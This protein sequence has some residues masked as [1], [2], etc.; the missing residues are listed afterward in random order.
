MDRRQIIAELDALTTAVKA[1]MPA[2]A[3]CEIEWM[4]SAELARRHALVLM[5][6]SFGQEREEA[7][8]RLALRIKHRRFKPLPLPKP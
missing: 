6:P 8:D 3:G 5:L 7:K 2:D 4:T 1:R